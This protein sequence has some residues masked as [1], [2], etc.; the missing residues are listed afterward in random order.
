MKD[1]DKKARA[2]YQKRYCAV[3]KKIY[4]LGGAKDDVAAALETTCPIIDE[5]E[6]KH[7]EFAEA[8]QAGRDAA[9]DC[10]ETSLRALCSGYTIKA[11][12]LYAHRGRVYRQQYTKRFL[13]DKAASQFWLTNQQRRDWKL[14]KDVPQQKPKDEVREWFDTASFET[15]DDVIRK[16]EKRWNRG[17][18]WQGS[19]EEDDTEPPEF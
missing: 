5:W 12:K 2:A 19:C 7:S 14:P 10:V 1:S 16:N 8:S 15:V 11:E 9:D 18:D 13:P 4:Q 3:A 6:N 17:P